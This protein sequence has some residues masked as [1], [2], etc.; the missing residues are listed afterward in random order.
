MRTNGFVIIIRIKIKYFILLFFILIFYWICTVLIH[1]LRLFP[2][3]C[4]SWLFCF[5]FWLAWV[6]RMYWSIVRVII[7][8]LCLYICVV[9]VW[10]S[11]HIIFFHSKCILFL[12]IFRSWFYWFLF[13]HLTHRI[14]CLWFHIF[15]LN[16]RWS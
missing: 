6:Y 11:N 8:I 9:I 7:V 5:S 15:L 16:K 2:S 10:H 12:F 13:L 4:N 14:W 1:I 3:Y